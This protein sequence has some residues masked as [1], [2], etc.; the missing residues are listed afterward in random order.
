MLHFI[1]DFIRKKG[2][3]LT[4]YLFVISFVKPYLKQKNHVVMSHSKKLSL[5]KISWR[6]WEIA[7]Y[8]KKF[9]ELTWKPEKFSKGYTIRNGSQAEWI[10]F[11]RLNRHS[12]VVF[13]ICEVTQ[14]K[15]N[16]VFFHFDNYTPVTHIRW[17]ALLTGKIGRKFIPGERNT[18]KFH[19]FW[20]NTLNFNLAGKT[21]K[22]WESSM[23]NSKSPSIKCKGFSIFTGIGSFILFPLAKRFSPGHWDRGV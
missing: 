18:R 3:V 19:P 13:I 23:E 20:K 21:R 1:L 22:F 11:T 5:W 9:R 14:C 7:E 17:D 12:L 15:N 16:N 10:T 2:N 6:A 4:L 8:P